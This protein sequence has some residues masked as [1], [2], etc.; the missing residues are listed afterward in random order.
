M[1][2]SSRLTLLFSW[3]NLFLTFKF[4]VLCHILLTLCFSLIKFCT[5]IEIE[6]VN[7]LRCSCVFFDLRLGDC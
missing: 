7:K 1:L 5:V 3:F 2:S 4:L 6:S